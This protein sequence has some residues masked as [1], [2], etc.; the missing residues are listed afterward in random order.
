MSL[1]GVKWKTIESKSYDH[2]KKED[3]LVWVFLLNKSL[4]IL[5]KIGY[6]IREKSLINLCCGQGIEG[7]YLA[8]KKK[9]MAI[10]LDLSLSMVRKA[11]N[12]FQV[13]C[14]D[15]ETLPFKNSSLDVGFVY[16][17]L[18]H[19]PNPYRAISELC[20]V[21]KDV[22]V[23]IDILD[24]LLTRL[25]NIFGFY[26][27]EG[28]TRI[29]PNRLKIEELKITLRQ[30]KTSY[31]ILYCFGYFPPSLKTNMLMRFL[32]KK[33]NSLLWHIPVLG[34]VFGNTAILIV[35]GP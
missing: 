2:W 20:R 29:K 15:A 10:G 26:R 9:M 23:I 31:V 35:Y 5:E 24:P 18:H 32:F 11:K 12:R 13:I 4:E 17:G 30:L 22:V 27:Y 21:N 7:A 1:D 19:L 34:S 16:N 3:T 8:K 25:L 33:F 14:G 6:D 28:H